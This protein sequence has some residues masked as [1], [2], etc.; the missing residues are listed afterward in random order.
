MNNLLVRGGKPLSGTISPSA[1][2][3]AALPILCAT[4]LTDEE[5]ILRGV[6]DITDVGQILAL[7]EALGG[8]EDQPPMRDYLRHALRLAD[9]PE[10][11]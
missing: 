1:N 8:E 4:L 7:L 9:D 11:T 10:L 2:N 6:P 3:N 5:V